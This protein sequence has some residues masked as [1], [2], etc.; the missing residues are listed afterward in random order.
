MGNPLNDF[1]TARVCRI[2]H[3]VR[4]EGHASFRFMHVPANRPTLELN[5]M[6]GPTRRTIAPAILAVAALAACSSA[7][8]SPA[9]ASPTPVANANIGPGS[10]YPFTPADVHFMTG[11][12]H[13][14]AQAVLMAGWAPTHG[15]SASLQSLCARIKV[16]QSDEILLMQ[17][18]LRDRHQPVPDGNPSHDMM[19][20]MEHMMMPGMLT[21]EQLKQLDDARGTEFDRLFLEFMIMHHQGAL[22]MVHELFST[23]AS[24]QDDIIF[25]FASDVNA[26][27]TTEI[28]RMGKMLDALSAGGQTP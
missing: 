4:P 1:P 26:D 21:P 2:V 7:T 3:T 14:H 13:H 5:R 22:T 20:G 12:I 24:G 16:G 8:R 27:Q 18:W 11:M 23:P 17:N 9:A 28:D 25:K 6:R 10:R 19:P 15:A